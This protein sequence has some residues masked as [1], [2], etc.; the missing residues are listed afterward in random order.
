MCRMTSRCV[1]RRSDPFA[2]VLLASLLFWVVAVS[3]SL[4]R[5]LRGKTCFHFPAL[6][7]PE[8]SSQRNFCAGTGSHVPRLHQFL[9]CGIKHKRTGQTQKFGKQSERGRPIMNQP[10]LSLSVSL[11]VS[12]SL[13]LSLSLCLSVSLCLS[14]SLSLSISV[15]LFL[16]LSVSLIQS[17]SVCLSVCLSVSA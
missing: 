7:A 17:L 15:S 13:S 8:D 1:R 16:Y 12:L 6:S 3:D 11:C 10:R 2:P 9:Q 5:F 14:L 4:A